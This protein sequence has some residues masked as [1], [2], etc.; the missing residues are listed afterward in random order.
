[1]EEI[2]D[3][4]AQGHEYSAWKVSRNVGKKNLE[5]VLANKVEEKESIEKN[6]V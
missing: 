6:D 5:D 1:L 3:V 4:F 2:E